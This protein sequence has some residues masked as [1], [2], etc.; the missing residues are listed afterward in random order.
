MVWDAPACVVNNAYSEDGKVYLTDSYSTFVIAV[1]VVINP[2]ESG[3]QPAAANP[4][5]ALGPGAD[6]PLLLNNPRSLSPI[7]RT[8]PNTGCLN[9]L[10]FLPSSPTSTRLLIVRASAGRVLL[11]MDG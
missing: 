7:L 3:L 10:C 2:Y 8:F 4:E 9:D 5:I 1:V 11:Q 6:S